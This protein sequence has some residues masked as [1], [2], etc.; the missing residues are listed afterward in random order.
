MSPSTLYWNQSQLL[1]LSTL[2]YQQIKEYEEK[3]Y[4]RAKCRFYQGFRVKDREAFEAWIYK[5]WSPEQFN[6][7]DDFR[8]CNYDELYARLLER[9]N[10][11]QRQIYD[12]CR[13]VYYPFFNDT[14]E[15]THREEFRAFYLIHRD[16]QFKMDHWLRWLVD[17]MPYYVKKIQRDVLEKALDPDGKIHFD[18]VAHQFEY[19][20]RIDERVH[21]CKGMIRDIV[22]DHGN[23][24]LEEFAYE[25]AMGDRYFVEF[26]ATV[27]EDFIKRCNMFLDLRQKH[28][29]FL[30]REARR[31]WCGESQEIRYF[32][33]VPK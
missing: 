31:A 25:V 20:R 18:S 24:T 7:E 10:N 33:R 9:F 19:E 29:Q 17:F 12:S 30:Q 32:T 2:S 28:H 16:Y 4:L 13:N 1:T 14:R 22:Y 26:N 15:R 23:S 5:Q 8:K 3:E 6:L 11:T 21:E 27:R